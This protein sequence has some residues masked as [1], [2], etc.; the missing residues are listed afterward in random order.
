MLPGYL[1]PA[2]APDGAWT[3]PEKWVW[4]Q[5][6]K[7]ERADFNARYAVTPADLAPDPRNAAGWSANRLLSSAFLELILLHAPYR[8]AL[9]RHGVRIIG[10]IIRQR[11]VGFPGKIGHLGDGKLHLRGQFVAG[12]AGG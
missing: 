1:S 3:E 9:P 10:A 4:E 6:C 7:G 11:G 2:V 12:D 8:D 5:V